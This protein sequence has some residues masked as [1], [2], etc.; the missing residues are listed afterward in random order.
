MRERKGGGRD[1]KL[2]EEGRGLAGLAIL[3]TVAALFCL[4]KCNFS[5]LQ[6]LEGS[7]R[8]LSTARAEGESGGYAC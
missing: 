8:I 2:E 5:S 1:F 4:V 7:I 3:Q 6:V